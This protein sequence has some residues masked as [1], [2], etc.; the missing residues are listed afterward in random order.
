MDSR[1]RGKDSGEGKS[2]I[3]K[4][5]LL[6]LIYHKLRICNLIK[7]R[8]DWRRLFIVFLLFYIFTNLALDVPLS[9]SIL[10]K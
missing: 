10:M 7:R 6:Q 3:P 8:P 2:Q 4:A 1:M 9:E 5:T